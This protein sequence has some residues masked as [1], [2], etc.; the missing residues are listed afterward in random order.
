MGERGAFDGVMMTECKHYWVIE[1][2]DVGVCKY[3]GRQKKFGR[4]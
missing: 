4:R 3:C 2:K 1:D